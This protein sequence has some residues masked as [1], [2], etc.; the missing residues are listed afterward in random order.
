MRNNIAKKRE[1]KKLKREKL[2]NRH[3]K[4]TQHTPEKNLDSYKIVDDSI[5]NQIMSTWK[6][7]G[8]ELEAIMKGHEF[9][10][11]EKHLSTI[12]ANSLEK[13]STEVETRLKQVAEDIEEELRHIISSH[14]TP[15]WL[16]LESRLKFSTS[17]TTNEGTVT[18]YRKT[19][20]ASIYKFG[21]D[22]VDDYNT[23]LREIRLKNI[24]HSDIISLYKIDRLAYALYMLSASLRNLWKGGIIYF[25]EGVH[26]FGFQHTPQTEEAI[27][28]MDSREGTSSLLSRSGLF[29][30][31]NLANI[32][33]K[34]AEKVFCPFPIYPHPNID[35][36]ISFVE[37]NPLKHYTKDILIPFPNFII[38][39]F[40]LHGVNECLKPYSN[41]FFTKFGFP[42]ESFVQFLMILFYRQHLLMSKNP[43]TAYQ[44][45]MRGNIH[46]SNDV[47]VKDIVG[48]ARDFNQQNIGHS[49]PE[50]ENGNIIAQ[51]ILDSISLNIHCD[52]EKQEIDLVSRTH[53]PWISK[54]SHNRIIIDYRNLIWWLDDF[55]YECLI[56]ADESVVNN[57]ADLFPTLIGAE[58]L[59][60]IPEIEIL[61]P[62]NKT[63]TGN[64][65]IKR[66]IDL[67]FKVKN[68]VFV[69]ECKARRQNEKKLIGEKNKI[70]T[71]WTDA[72]KD[73]EQVTTLTE[74]I[75]KNKTFI[76]NKLVSGDLLVP[77]VLY[78]HVGWIPC[79]KEPYIILNSLPRLA[80]P[81]ELIHFLRSNTQLNNIEQDP[82]TLKL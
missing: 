56:S 5:R 3:L 11:Y 28:W 10:I 71:G 17:F 58:L 46:T 36:K 32:L 20:R 19:L 70:I 68:I 61:L 7:H 81:T 4:K 80:T 60:Q 53:I 41:Y 40:D 24:Q 59:R 31:L 12:K 39:P 52:K 77:L 48:F 69:C 30:E 73:L 76:S 8:T 45:I 49:F 14:S 62:Y 29:L 22:T 18:L 33:K 26:Y 67:I 64:A 82:L 47:I 75:S 79:K 72:Q 44:I 74:F 65:K 21:N 78:P 6:L 1:Q 23:D 25:Q 50:G 38:H 15:Y 42:S 63:V 2:K 27:D 57:S 54:Y 55:I 16:I 35:H 34:Q 43:L 9:P 51:K 66:E 13:N 37:E